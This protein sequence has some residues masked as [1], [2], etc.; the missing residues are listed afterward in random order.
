MITVPEGLGPCKVVDQD[1]LQHM[2]QN[3]WRLVAVVQ[4]QTTEPVSDNTPNPQTGVMEYITRYHPST[5]TR[6]LV[7]QSPNEAMAELQAKLDQA[8]NERYEA[9]EK[10]RKLE[11]N[12]TRVER[13][14]EEQIRRLR[15]ETENAAQQRDKA[16]TELEQAGQKLSELYEVQDQMKR[17]WAQLGVER[18]RQLLGEG[19]E[20]PIPVP[21]PKSAHERIAEA[22]EGDDIPF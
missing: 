20:C 18:M 8:E 3:G 22:V 4:E 16:Y 7:T 9:Q 10:A 2:T 15:R 14:C 17:L 21:E 5:T 6:F 13:E 1:T 12:V 19:V 11:D